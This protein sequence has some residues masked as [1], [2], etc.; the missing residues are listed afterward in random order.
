MSTALANGVDV[1]DAATISSPIP[2]TGTAVSN[3]APRPPTAGAMPSAIP[4]SQVYFWTSRWQRDE[5][6]AIEELR[7]GLGRC[8]DD[9]TEAIRWLLS[10]DD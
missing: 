6:A 9:A 10:D 1:F 8:F 5:A 2:T 3:M 4:R 7:N